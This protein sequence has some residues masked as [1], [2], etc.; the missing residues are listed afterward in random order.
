[1]PC[2]LLRLVF[3]VHRRVQVR[4]GDGNARSDDRLLRHDVSEEDDARED[5][6]DALDDVADAVRDWADAV[7]RLVCKLVV[8]VV[9]DAN[10][11]ELEPEGRRAHRRDGRL[12]TLDDRSTL[13][14]E[15]K[16]RA[17][18]HRDDAR[19][20][21]VVRRREVLDIRLALLHPHGAE[22]EREVREHSGDEAEPVEGHLG[23]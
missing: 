15:S 2:G 21:V 11:E 9:E 7:E 14:D 13:E 8:E 4:A 10:E 18:E 3:L 19:V 6:D 1:M 16:R 5:D 17:D 12:G 20:G 22:A 23:G